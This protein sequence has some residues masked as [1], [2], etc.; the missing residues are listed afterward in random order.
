M[1]PPTN[2]T[3]STT[4]IEGLPPE[5]INELFKHLHPRDLATCSMVNKRWHS[6]YAAFKVESLIKICSYDHIRR[7]WYH[8]DREIEEKELC[9]KK[10]FCRMV[11]RPLLSNLKHLAICIESSEFDLDKLNQFS[12]LVHLEIGYSSC[13]ID[14]FYDS[15]NSDVSDVEKAILSLPKLEVLALFKF[16]SPSPLLVDCPM[17]SVLVYDGEYRET[18]KVKHPETIRILDTGMYGSKLSQFKGV[19]C[20]IA[21]SYEAISRDTLLRLPKLKEIRDD[22]GFGSS[23]LTGNEVGTLDKEKR[24]LKEFLDDVKELKGDH[25][26]FIYGGFPLTKKMLD[27]IDFGLILNKEGKELLFAEYICTKNHELLEPGALNLSTGVNYS[28][29]QFFTGEFPGSIKKFARICHLEADE[30]VKDVP[31][32]LQFLKSL[33]FLRT[34]RLTNTGLGQEFFEQLPA[35]VRFLSELKVYEGDNKMQLDFN[36][37]SKLPF[38]IFCTIAQERFTV[39]SFVTL[40]RLTFGK[41]SRGLFMFGDKYQIALGKDKATKW[42]TVDDRVGRSSRTEWDDAEEVVNWLEGIYPEL[43]Q[44]APLKSS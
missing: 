1:N 5:M 3:T 42:W 33:S 17:L 32:F 18:F 9:S 25:F 39:E 29:L 27:Q 35:T 20:L 19:E 2:P 43:S 4:S 13:F 24:R 41:L 31:L 7:G 37:I 8:S 12:H 15:D 36:F 28:L 14:S 40:V 23:W 6:I 44:G 21:Q 38:L 34:L 11:D 22:W 10:L 26:K 30:P 16:E